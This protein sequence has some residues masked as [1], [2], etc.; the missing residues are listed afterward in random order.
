L[1]VPS[2]LDREGITVKASSVFLFQL[3]TV[4][5]GIVAVVL[6]LAEPLVERRNAHATLFATYFKDPFLAYVYVGSIPFFVALYRAF[7]L[8]RQVRRTGVFSSGSLKALRTIKWCALAIIGFA[9]GAAAIM[10]LFGDKTERPAGFFM[11]LLII[12]PASA[13][14][15]AASKFARR[16]QSTLS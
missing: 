11:C 15:L 9:T 8:S 16:L 7:G 2:H 13:V 3:G 14:A 12:A 10:L 6:L 1:R 5:I 4:L